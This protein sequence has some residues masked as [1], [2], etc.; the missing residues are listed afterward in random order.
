MIENPAL[1][2]SLKNF[3]TDTSGIGFFAALLPKLVALGFTIG[4]IIFFFIFITGAIAWISSGKDKNALEEARTKLVN[5]LIGLIVL[6][7]SFA[8]MLFIQKFFGVNILQLDIGGL[9]I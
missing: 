1:G 7:T 5:G 3:S 6:F 4:V 2:P 8:I 9:K